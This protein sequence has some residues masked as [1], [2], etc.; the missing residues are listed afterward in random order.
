MRLNLLIIIASFSIQFIYPQNV[1][2]YMR[3][4]DE[5]F[6]PIEQ[7][8]IKKDGIETL[9]VKTR[10][11]TFNSVLSQSKIKKFSQAFPIV[12]D[13]WLQKVYLVESEESLYKNLTEAKF[14]NEISHIELLCEPSLCY[15]PND[16]SLSYN[17]TNLDLIKVKDA[18]DIV[19]TLPKLPIGVTDTYFDKTHPDLQNQFINIVGNSSPDGHGTAVAGLL[20]A[21]TDNAIGISAIS[22]NAKIYASTNWGSDNEVLSLAQQG[23]RVINCS[24]HNS[25][26]YS[27]IQDSLYKKIRD[28]WNTIV[29][30]SAGNVASHCGSLTAKVYPASYSSVLSVTSVGHMKPV[31]YID[32]QW[33]TADWIDC[34]EAVVGDPTS[35]HHHNDAVDICAPGYHV[36]TT[37][38]G[39]GYGGAWGTSFAAPQVAATACL[40]LSVNPCLSAQQAMNIIKNS[41]DPSIYSISYNAPYIGLLGTGRLDVAAA[42]LAAA[43]SATQTFSTPTIL[44]GTQTIET[45]YAIENTASVQIVSGAN[46]LFKTRKEVIL[47]A[48]FEV[49]VGATFEIDVD[50]NNVINCN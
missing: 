39:G 3:I 41:A 10:S 37:L 16:Y 25:C 40:V 17:Q 15:T 50:S 49:A 45:N 38:Y 29:V 14:N 24:W 9:E 35:S 36:P 18:W 46:I 33:G 28:V 48:G 8:Q 43:Q 42:C 21:Q 30:F 13:E 12:K 26:S 44:L 19:R 27:V 7:E 5:K 11:E 6:L 2:F 4:E 23:Y 32:P 47:N 34:H 1:T 22:F 20:S 31:G